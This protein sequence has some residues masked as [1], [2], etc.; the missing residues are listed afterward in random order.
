MALCQIRANC[1]TCGSPRLFKKEGTSNI[2]HLL[3]TVMTFGVWLPIWIL[4]AV[5]NAFKPFR[6]IICGEP[7]LR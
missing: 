3:F 4:C 2:L 1:R 6:C 7:K 5:L